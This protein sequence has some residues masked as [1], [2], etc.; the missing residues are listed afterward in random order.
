MELSA[1]SANAKM[2]A[3]G[4]DEAMTLYPAASQLSR[5]LNVLLKPDNR[6]TR[7]ATSTMRIGANHVVNTDSLLKRP[8]QVGQYA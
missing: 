1:W 7:R 5:M 3:I 6:A 8:E 4:L 2:D